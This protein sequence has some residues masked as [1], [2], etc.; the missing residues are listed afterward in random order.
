MS[1]TRLDPNSLASPDNPAALAPVETPAWWTRFWQLRHLAIVLLVTLSGPIVGSSYVL[2]GGRVPTDPMQ[3][4]Y[5][6]VGALRGE[7]TS[8]LLLWY[9][10]GRQGKTWKD[11]G[12]KV[13]I[14]D[15][16]L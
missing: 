5:R 10:L 4:S 16:P 15:V 14:A 3:Q 13:G 8:L 6:L 7:A 11:I 12:W 2:L 1:L 9:V